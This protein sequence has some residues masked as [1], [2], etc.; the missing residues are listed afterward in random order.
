MDDGQI[1][2]TP[3]K[4]AIKAAQDALNGYDPSWGAIYYYNPKK[5]SNRFMKSRPVIRVI[6]EHVF[7]N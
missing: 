3:V 1:N 6:G 4:S 5:T 7:C 2:Y